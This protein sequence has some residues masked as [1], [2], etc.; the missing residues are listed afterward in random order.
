MHTVPATDEPANVL[1]ELLSKASVCELLDNV[2]PKHVENLVRSGRMPPP[3]Y[4]G[5]SPRWQRRV[6]LE[7][8]ES[9]CP[10]VDAE[11]FDTWQAMQSA[12][13]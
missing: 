5:R 7:W 13:H 8:I 6:L 12:A 1:P 11:R 4:L 3:V 2:T 9:G 10:V